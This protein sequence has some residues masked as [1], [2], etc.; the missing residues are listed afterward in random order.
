MNKK[1][2]WLGMNYSTAVAKLARDLLFDFVSKA[3]ICCFR[4]GKP[5]SRD[6]FSIDHKHAWRLAESP[7]S[8]FF[9]LVN[10][11]YS[12]KGCNSVH[13]NREAAPEHGYNGYKKGCR[14]LICK[15]GRRASR[16][17]YSPSKRRER[18]L[19]YGT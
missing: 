12:H 9:D 8:A 6:D 2:V 1:S 3:G 7:A 17:Q 16:A 19:N 18:Y 11:A 14:C 15:Q 5:L 4:C 13:N 10:V